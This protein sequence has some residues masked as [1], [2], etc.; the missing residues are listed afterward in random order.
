M[1]RTSLYILLLI[2]YSSITNSQTLNIYYNNTIDE[3]DQKQTLIND[4]SDIKTKFGNV[5]DEHPDY[6]RSD[7]TIDIIFLDTSMVCNLIL[8]GSHNAKN[9]LVNN[10][11]LSHQTSPSILLYFVKRNGVYVLRSIKVSDVL[12]NGQIPQI[13]LDYI[14]TQIANPLSKDYKA[15]SKATINAFRN[16]FNLNHKETILTEGPLMRKCTYYYKG[17]AYIDVKYFYTQME[18]ISRPS[19]YSDQIDYYFNSEY[20]PIYLTDKPD[21]RATVFDF[22]FGHSMQANIGSSYVSQIQNSNKYVYV[23][24]N[25]VHTLLT[26]FDLSFD[27]NDIIAFD[28]EDRST[29]DAITDYN[30]L[31]NYAKSILE[32]KYILI[33]QPDES[34][35]NEMQLVE[36]DNLVSENTRYRIYEDVTHRID[37][38]NKGRPQD[39]DIITPEIGWSVGNWKTKFSY[40]QAT[41]CNWYANDLSDLS[42][43]YGIP[44]GKS[45]SGIL[46]YIQENSSEYL[47]LENVKLPEDVDLETYIWQYLVDNGYPVYFSSSSHIETAFPSGSSVEKSNRRYFEDDNGTFALDQTSN[48]LTIGGGGHTGFKSYNR[49]SWLKASNTYIYLYLGYLKD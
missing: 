6:T 28:D 43:F 8:E 48:S 35:N 20:Y 42:G 19:Y 9:L 22:L 25:G 10:W 14:H 5:L 36:T 34:N 47:D 41:W 24:Q 3:K 26:E 16:A 40:A 29:A 31:K 7:I 30:N 27:I 4:I 21:K 39:A 32:S 17:F 15:C 23:E 2:L 46:N 13:V 37:R 49:Y 38:T 45:A 12:L 11:L 33:L 44:Y 1:K 18:N